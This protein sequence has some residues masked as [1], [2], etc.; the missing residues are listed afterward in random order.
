MSVIFPGYLP[1][2]GLALSNGRINTENFRQ[3]TFTVSW[4]NAWNLDSATAPGN[5]DAAWIF[6][7]YSFGDSWQHLDLSP[8]DV[9]QTN[10][11]DRLRVEPALDGK[12]VFL[13][14][15][16]SGTG[17]IDSVEVTL[18]LNVPLRPPHQI[19]FLTCGIEMAYVPEGAFYLGDGASNSSFWAGDSS[20]PFWIK[21]ESAID[22]GNGADDLGRDSVSGSA[23]A[24]PESWPKGSEGFYCM[25]Y[26]IS[27]EQYGDF[28]QT[29]T[30]QQQAARIAVSPQSPPGTFALSSGA[31]FR[32]GI[33]LTLPAN[34][35]G[36]VA[37]FGYDLQADFTFNEEDDGQNR[38]CNWLSWDDLCAYLD[39]A[40]LRPLSEFEYEKACRG[41]LPPL[42]LEFAWGTDEIVDANTLI[43]DGT[44][45]EAVTEVVTGNEGLASQGYAGPQG[46]LRC[47]FAAAENTTRREAGAGYYGVMEMSG[48]L[49]EQ[50]VVTNP[51]GLIFVANPGDGNLDTEGKANEASWPTASG[52]GHRGGAWN[53][54][55]L[56]GFRDLAVSDR[57]YAGLAPH[58]RRNTVGG[59]GGRCK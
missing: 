1:A 18:E 46:P 48:N 7:K 47:G 11:P 4:Q 59:R 24:V 30:A 25:K 56:P 32:N 43:N 50:C 9:H 3:V 39:W 28:L 27:Q 49:W 6:V 54:G 12:G 15:A 57:F 20:G 21:D 14:P 10:A 26:E 53:S 55:V 58:T 37:G 36:A 5:H 44:A 51:D 33:H 22:F 38:A 31:P 13:I 17:H 29:L 45:N 23:N 16:F 52:A 19:F 35:F 41:P 8:M 40:C 34:G 2:S 42:P